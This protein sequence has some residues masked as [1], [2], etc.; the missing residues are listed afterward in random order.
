MI[1]FF[2]AIAMILKFLSLTEKLMFVTYENDEDVSNSYLQ[3]LSR[4]FYYYCAFREVATYYNNDTKLYQ[5]FRNQT[6]I[7]EQFFIKE[8][9]TNEKLNE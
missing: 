6:S 9:K 2:V 1:Y 5:E 4:S 8:W 7:E 3:K